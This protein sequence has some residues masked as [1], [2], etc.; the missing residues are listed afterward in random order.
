MLWFGLFEFLR[1]EKNVYFLSPLLLRTI[2]LA[3]YTYEYH[4]KNSDVFW[5]IYDILFFLVTTVVA[6][7]SD[8]CTWYDHDLQT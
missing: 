5:K 8:V 7:T 3:Y 4:G 6:S 1:Y 2:V